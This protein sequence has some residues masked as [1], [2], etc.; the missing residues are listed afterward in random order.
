M[1]SLLRILTVVLGAV[2]LAVPLSLTA[3]PAEAASPK[4]CPNGWVCLY[5]EGAD[6]HKVN[7]E[8]KW[9]KYQTYN[10]KAVYGHHWLYNNQWGN[11]YVIAFDGYNGTGECFGF[12]GRGMSNWYWTPINSI[13]LSTSMPSRCDWSP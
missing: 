9:F 6:P 2:A 11:A 4:G 10:L 12:Y 13:R 7:P 8:Q 1:S 3:V 5:P